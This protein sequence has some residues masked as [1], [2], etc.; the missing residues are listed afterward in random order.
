MLLLWISSSFSEDM[1]WLVSSTTLS[2][3]CAH[4]TGDVSF[5]SP[6]RKISWIRILS[7]NTLPFGSVRMAGFVSIQ[8][9]S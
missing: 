6:P 7:S 4:P 5:F 1:G 8:Y 2:M 3:P 9:T